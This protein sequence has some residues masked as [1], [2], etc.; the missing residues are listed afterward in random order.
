MR[1]ALVVVNKKA[2]R[3]GG[4]VADALAALREGGIEPVEREVF[5]PG[6]LP[7]L[8]A[9]MK[10]DVD[11]VVLGGGDG[12]MSTAAPGL[13]ESGLPL[14][15]LP[16]GTANDLAHTLGLPLDPV[17][18]AR[19]VVAGRTE[20]ID[21]GRVNDSYFF[22]VAHLGLSV[23]LTNQLT[24]AAKRMFGKLSY[25]YCAL[26]V[27]ARA[28][29]FAAELT[30]DEETVLARTIQIAIGNGKFYGGGNA[31]AADAA[32]DDG[33]FDVYS[34]EPR[35]PWRVV[36]ML[37]W[38]RRGTHGTW[39]EVRTLRCRRLTIRTRRPRSI[40]TDGEITTATPAEF[41]VLN[42]AVTVFVP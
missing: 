14:G 25:A 31:V 23:T 2:R 22:N 11:L 29:R 5:S 16:L 28:R 34:L 12:T 3:G 27:I 9:H 1:R 36:P 7:R 24:P 18:A 30:C 40:T 35:N 10:A 19:V 6:D 15:I 33:H 13:L 38:F 21:L 17:E 4:P 37:P 20:R 42:G 32:I 8:I 26:K 41:E 39:S